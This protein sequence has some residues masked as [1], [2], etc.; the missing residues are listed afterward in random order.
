MCSSDLAILTVQQFSETERT[1]GRRLAVYY[2]LP[3]LP[4]PRGRALPAAYGDAGAGHPDG[5]SHPL[6]ITAEAPGVSS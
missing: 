5:A 4:G 6:A 3:A 1:L 2:A